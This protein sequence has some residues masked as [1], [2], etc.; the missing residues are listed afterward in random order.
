LLDFFKSATKELLLYI[1]SGLLLSHPVLS[2]RKADFVPRLCR[3]AFSSL[4]FFVT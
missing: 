2:D 1:N 4:C 3:A